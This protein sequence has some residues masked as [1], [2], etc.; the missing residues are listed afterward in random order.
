MLSTA[1]NELMCRVAADAPQGKALRRFW[2]PA[3]M[4]SELPTPD[5]DPVRVQVL[6]E[7]LIA[8][9]DTEGQVGVLDEFC[10]HRSAS[11]S[12]GR[13]EECGIRCIYHGRKFDRRGN[14]LDTPNV[15][16]PRFKDRVRAKAYPVFEGGGLVWVYVGPAELQPPVPAYPFMNLSGAHRL[17][18]MAVVECNFTQVMEGLLDSSH[19][20]ILH[21]A[22]L[23][24]SNKS[25]LAFAAKSNHMQF[26][27]AP[28]IESDETDFGFQYVAIRKVSE[29]GVERIVARVSAFH[30][31]CFVHNPNGACGSPV[32]L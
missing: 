26:D 13:V 10:R 5:S 24:S 30:A 4:S 29:G 6:G 14:I 25:D 21:T 3:V 7:E 27:T 32:Y 1:E 12:L 11:L 2:L 8:F 9:R 17:T 20:S 18:A 16:D 28:R 31:P 19:L 15:A 22:G 23:E